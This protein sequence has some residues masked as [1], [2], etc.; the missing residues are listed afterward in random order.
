[1]IVRFIVHLT[2][3]LIFGT[4][5]YLWH[6]EV[7]LGKESPTW[8]TTNAIVAEASLGGKRSHFSYTFQ[9]GDSSFMGHKLEF[10]P[11]NDADLKEFFERNVKN[12]KEIT[13]SYCPSDPAYS[14]IRPG[15]DDRQYNGY[16]ILAGFLLAFSFGL[17]RFCRRYF[18][19]K[20]RTMRSSECS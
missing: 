4:F 11:V 17:D 5:A 14:V 7:E 3:L 2:L 9:A 13:I 1:M 15:M 10:C 16:F 19:N 12:R 8:P 18:K 6:E 20:C